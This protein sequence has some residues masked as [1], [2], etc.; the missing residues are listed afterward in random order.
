[1]S[2]SRSGLS[3]QRFTRNS[4]SCTNLYKSVYPLYKFVRL[5]LHPVQICTAQYALCTNLYTYR[6]NLYCPL[7]CTTFR[8]VGLQFSSHRCGF[9]PHASILQYKHIR[10][11][12][13]IFSR[14]D[15]AWTYSTNRYSNSIFVANF[16]TVLTWSSN[17]LYLLCT[18]WYI[19]NDDF[20][21]YKF[22]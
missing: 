4:T 19:S 13:A 5:S 20:F 12:S 10:R 17:R 21:T 15:A 8:Y 1:M 3:V 22:A 18:T 6:T 7:N 2:S 16:Y 9:T 14:A 11:L